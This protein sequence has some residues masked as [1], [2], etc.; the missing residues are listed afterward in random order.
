MLG[1]VFWVALECCL[2]GDEAG[3]VGA[4]RKELT[5]GFGS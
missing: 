4:L 3:R 1:W 2:G 5:V